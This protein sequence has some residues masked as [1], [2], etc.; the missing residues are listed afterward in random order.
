M[1]ALVEARRATIGHGN[2]PCF[3]RVELAVQPGCV[4]AVLG[5]NGVGKTTLLDTLAGMLPTLSG[6]VSLCGKEPHRLTAR[7]RA[8][9]AAAVPQGEPTDHGLTALETVALGRFAHARGPFDRPGDAEAARRALAAAGVEELAGRPF[10]ELSAGQRQCVL[11]ARAV[12]QETPVLLADEPTANLDPAWQILVGQL[13][14]RL[15]R[16]GK[17]VVV[18]T[19]DL[20]WAASF[21]DWAVLFERG[22]QA[23]SGES[24]EVIR[25][26]VLEPVYGSRFATVLD[27]LPVPDYG[28]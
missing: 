3:E 6:S 28:L 11:V 24:S 7:A 21:A 9:L 4:L 2:R 12:A 8:L 1:K 22:R 27:G 23:A 26:E 18:A 19:H 14:R 15:A 20:F 25:P 10:C 5:P 13:L 16:E 17:A